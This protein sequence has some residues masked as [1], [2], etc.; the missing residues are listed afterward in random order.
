M[1][2]SRYR[3]I[4]AYVNRVT[5]A[6]PIKFEDCITLQTFSVYLISCRNML[7]ERIEYGSEY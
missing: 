5:E 3:I 2:S 1:D 7:K 4:R 6:T